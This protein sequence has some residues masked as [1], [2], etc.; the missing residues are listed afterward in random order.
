ME[1][2]VPE[3]RN[4]GAPELF[5]GDKGFSGMEIAVTFSFQV[6]CLLA[7]RLRSI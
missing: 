2:D 6:R 5:R 1:E 3:S 4:R 7:G